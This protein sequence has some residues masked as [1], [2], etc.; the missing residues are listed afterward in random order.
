M[1]QAAGQEHSV[2]WGA[3]LQEREQRAHRA[4]QLAAGLDDLISA[5]EGA[6]AGALL[7]GWRFGDTPALLRVLLAEVADAPPAPSATERGWVLSP[8][9]SD[10]GSAVPVQQ[11]AWLHHQQ[12][13][14]WA[15]PDGVEGPERAQ[16]WA[17]AELGF[18]GEEVE[19]RERAAWRAV[20]YAEQPKDD[21]AVAL[22]W[23]SWMSGSA[24]DLR[25][26]WEKRFLPATR[27]VFR[28]V[29]SARSL[30]EPVVQRAL[31]DLSEA[32]FY[33]LLSGWPELA[34]RVLETDRVVDTLAGSLSEGR[35]RTLAGCVV[36]RG[37]WR[38]TAALVWDSLPELASRARA[39]AREGLAT[40]ERLERWMDLHAALRMVA[41]WRGDPG[42]DAWAVVR[43]NRGRARGRLRALAMSAPDSLHDHL[44]G[45]EGLAARTEAAVRR[46]A[47][48]WAW[49]ELALDFSFDIARTVTPPCEP[50][51]ALPEPLPDAL[52]PAL[53]VWVLLV[54]FRG[55]VEHLRRWVATGSTGDRDS[56]WARLLTEA[57]PEALAD[58]GEPG[59][60][61]RG[62]TYRRLR[63][64]LAERLP[65]LLQ[66][67][68]PL[69]AQIASLSPGRGLP[70]QLSALLEGRW[71]ADV[72]YPRSGF[73][74]IHK[75]AGAFLRDDEG[76]L[77]MGS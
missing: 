13:R 30:P 53:E 44:L 4:L 54:I 22:M 45:L 39:L 20:R 42:S 61:Q 35:W 3:F 57:L 36:S 48:A 38:Q 19:R 41:S 8:V 34:A 9:P 29:C 58:P 37:G 70:A 6:V 72:P 28:G 63:A 56:T 27:Q 31:S 40:P 26:R 52:L 65:E 7:G 51:E 46:Y 55:R 5:A 71:H 33:H 10:G 67:L 32:F 2:G 62:R 74:S 15:P 11:A 16:A 17:L 25:R 66:G 47:W 75:H 18:F 23:A 68:R 59:A 60:E 12:V 76:D 73:P 43:Q 50:A 21:A 64:D 49:K 14:A 77:E 1:Q 24:W 69:L